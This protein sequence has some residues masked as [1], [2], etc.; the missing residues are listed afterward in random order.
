MKDYLIPLTPRDLAEL[1]APMTF[2]EHHFEGE[3]MTM[4]EKPR[5]SFLEKLNCRCRHFTGV[6]NDACAA[7]IPYESL[8]GER[9]LMQIPC[10]HTGKHL[11]CEK[12]EYLTAEEIAAEDAEIEAS[13]LRTSAAI[14]AIKAH[15]GGQRG[16][17][18]EIE[19]PTCKGRLRF[20]VAAC[21]GHIHAK[22]STDDCVAF[23]Q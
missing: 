4:D 19:C 1:S 16:V 2:G 13:F 11:P 5:L 20:T 12:R 6:Q 3:E 7:G 10:I 21:N 15:V 22:C 23:M 18:D 14:K 17:R 8:R 9:G